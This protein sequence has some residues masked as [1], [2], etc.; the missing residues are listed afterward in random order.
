MVAARVVAARIGNFLR[1]MPRADDLREPLSGRL[2]SQERQ[3]S[4]CAIALAVTLALCIA[5]V[6]GLP[7]LQQLEIWPD[8]EEK[9]QCNNTLDLG[10]LE[11]L[12]KTYH[13]RK[14]IAPTCA[15]L[16]ESGKYS[17]AVDFCAPSDDGKT[18][19]ALG[20]TYDEDGYILTPG[21]CDRECNLGKV[22]KDWK[23]PKAMMCMRRALG[24]VEMMVIPRARSLTRA[25]DYRTSCLAQ[26]R[27]DGEGTLPTASRGTFSYPTKLTR[28]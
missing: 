23:P 2:V 24:R 16:V 7:E 15:E 21:L 20:P 18:T 12:N 13:R 25:H 28:K 1:V 22:C 17:C 4:C 3:G 10:G 6:V 8:E 5:L 14:P 26:L 27:S 11:A 9:W 19:C